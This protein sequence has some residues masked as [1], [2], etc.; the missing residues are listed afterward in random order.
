M[1]RHVGIIS[2]VWHVGKS[3]RKYHWQNV[4]QIWLHLL[5]LEKF[6]GVSWKCNM[7]HIPNYYSA[8]HLLSHIFWICWSDNNVPQDEKKACSGAD[9]TPPPNTYIHAHTHPKQH[10]LYIG[11]F[12]GNERAGRAAGQSP[13]WGQMPAGEFWEGEPH[14]A[15]SLLHSGQ[16]RWDQLDLQNDFT[17]PLVTFYF[18][19]IIKLWSIPH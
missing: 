17:F 14:Q 6:F 11:F 1:I 4:L 7:C 19:G 12:K 15:T 18:L 3:Y 16:E 10:N 13:G 9:E 8:P 5:T 2:L